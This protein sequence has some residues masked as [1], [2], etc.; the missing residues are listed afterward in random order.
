[1]P[2]YDDSPSG[3][4][5]GGGGHSPLDRRSDGR[6]PIKSPI[7]SDGRRRGGGGQ[8]DS[9]LTS[10]SMR[11][12]SSRGGGGGGGDPYDDYRQH[13]SHHRS[14]ESNSS[15]MPYKI[16]C[17]SNISNKCGDSVVRDALTR[18]FDRFG[19]PNVKLVYDDNTRL[20]YLY[21]RNYDDARDARH[22]KS[23]LVLFDKTVEIDPI[24]DRT[25]QV[26]RR[27]SISPDYQRGSMR[28]PPSPPMP[29]GRPLPPP[30]MRNNMND[31]KY[32][33]VM[34]DHSIGFKIVY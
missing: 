30:P 28:G 24:Y 3:H 14:S 29:R 31:M 10:S 5:S 27:R 23:R 9:P 17:V 7:I 18:E 34:T 25:I 15:S 16:L 21:F 1:M 4:R 19:A 2:R 22:A 33:P 32:M 13:S 26:P 8:R 20:A 12:M 11:G 6:R